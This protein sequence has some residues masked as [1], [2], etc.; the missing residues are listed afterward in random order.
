MNED[1][2]RPKDFVQVHTPPKTL[3]TRMGCGFFFG[4]SIEQLAQNLLL[5][6]KIRLSGAVDSAELRLAMSVVAM[7]FACITEPLGKQCPL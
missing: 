4:Q 3:E 6:H 2:V 1:L 5:A 7:G